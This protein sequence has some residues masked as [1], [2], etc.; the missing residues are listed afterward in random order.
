LDFF[1]H[2]ATAFCGGEGFEEVVLAVED[3]DA[4]GGVGFVAR[5][6]VEVGV[7]G[8]KVDFHVGDGLGAVDEDEGVG[9]FSGEGDDLLD[10]VED[11]EGVG[12][13]VDGDELGAVVEKGGV[14]FDV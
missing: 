12:D 11:A 6:G 4:G 14:G 1:N 7:K 10:R 9:F 13:V 3:A 2:F 8:L 5:K